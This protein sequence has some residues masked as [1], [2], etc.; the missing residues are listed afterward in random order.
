MHQDSIFALHLQSIHQCFVLMVF[1]SYTFSEYKDLAAIGYSERYEN[2]LPVLES[3]VNDYEARVK[4]H[5]KKM[6]FVW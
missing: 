5:L 1:L 2:T 3:D 4:E 6:G